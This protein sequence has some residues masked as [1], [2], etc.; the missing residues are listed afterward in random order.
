MHA[1]EQLRQTAAAAAQQAYAPY[2]GLRVGA[3]L[4][5]ASGQI[6]CGCN[7]ENGALPIGGCAER[8]A[9]AAA[10]LAEGPGFRLAAIA[11]VAFGGD[12]QTLPVPPCGACR[13]A[14]VEFGADAAVG[15]LGAD[16]SWK[17]TT[18]D[19]LLPHRFVLPEDR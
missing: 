12:G 2:S 18:A 15:F 17:V 10:V 11:V 16:G 6:H 8:A 3:A 5:S 1:T 14:L 13:Q 9:L 19:A 4:R 7:V